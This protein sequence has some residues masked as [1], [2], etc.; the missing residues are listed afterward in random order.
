MHKSDI[1]NI[2]RSRTKK[3]PLGSKRTQ[4]KIMMGCSPVTSKPADSHYFV[5]SSDMNTIASPTEQ[6]SSV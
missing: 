3:T 5:S 6:Y 2:E 1:N 4:L